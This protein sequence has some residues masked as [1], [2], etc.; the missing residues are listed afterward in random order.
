M[1]K[2]AHLTCTGIAA[3]LL[4]GGA[5]AATIN[6]GTYL[7]SSSLL[8][9]SSGANLDNSYVFELG[10]FGLTFTPTAANMNSWLANWKPFDRAQAPIASGFNPTAGVVGSFATLEVDYTTSEATLPQTNLFATG[11]Q[12]YIWVY[13]STPGNPNPMPTLVAS[14]WA[15]VTNNATD[16]DA[17][18]DWRMPAPG[19]HLNTSYDWRIE[20]GTAVV[21]GG[22]NDTQGAGNFTNTPA[23]FTLQTHATVAPVPEPT[24]TLLLASTGLLS[25]FRRRRP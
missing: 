24:G 20:D 21:F 18:D 10:T 13:Q 3:L 6:W 14:E 12:A 7:T 1:K 17:L 15:L 22:L 19:G 25:L 9:N 23:A 8:Y 5:E 2:L 16:G 11:E 4:Q